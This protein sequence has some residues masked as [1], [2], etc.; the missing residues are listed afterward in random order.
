MTARALRAGFGFGPKTLRVS[1]SFVN[2][3]GLPLA[4]RKTG[5]VSSTLSVAKALVPVVGQAVNLAYSG[6]FF[7]T[8]FPATENPLSQGG[9]FLLGAQASPRTNAQSAANHA[10]GTMV[11]TSGGT[12]YEDSCAIL[13]APFHANQSAQATIWNTGAVAGLEVEL[14]LRGSIS[15]GFVQCYEIDFVIEQGGF[16]NIANWK[17]SPTSLDILASTFGSGN[18]TYNDGDVVYA[19]IVGTLITVKINNVTKLTCDTSTFPG[20]N[21][22]ITSGSPGISFWNQTGSSSNSPNFG[23]KDFTAMGLP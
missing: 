13:A 23:F 15:S 2:A 21:Y 12:D 5:S 20:S 17:G 6:G 4:M 14:L 1:R 10:Y 18:I 8:N 19:D 16:I 22:P 3:R 11:S 9:A 7:T